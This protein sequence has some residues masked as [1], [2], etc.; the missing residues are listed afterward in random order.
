MVEHV[1]LFKTK[2]GTT[3]E[4]KQNL[5]TALKA[6]KDQIPG[7]VHLT[8]G[9]NFSDR[10]QGYD[11]GLSVRFEDRA[12]LDAYGPHPAHQACV[13]QFVIPIRED[14]IVADYEID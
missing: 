3:D 9:P 1:V 11:L 12:S 7:I 13:A 6:L 2:P 4:Q 10:S 8:A 14:I 5:I